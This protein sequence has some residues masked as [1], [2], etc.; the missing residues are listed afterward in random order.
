M[1]LL[2]DLE[3]STVD[4]DRGDWLDSIEKI[5]CLVILDLDTNN[6]EKYYDTT[7]L[8]ELG[9]GTLRAGI[10]KLGQATELAGHNIIQFDVPVLRRLHGFRT[11]AKI[12]DTLVISR[13]LYPDRPGGH[14]LESWGTKL[15]CP[16]LE[17]NEFEEF[18]LDMLEYCRRDVEL[19][20]RVYKAL[21][22]ESNTEAWRG[23]IDLEHEFAR[24]ITEQEQIGFY[25]DTKK[26]ERLVKEWEDAI[27]LGDSMVLDGVHSRVDAG[28]NYE[29]PFKINGDLTKR[30]VD[31][32]TAT[33]IDPSTVCGPFST[34]TYKVPELE[35]KTQQ[36]DLLLSMGWK[37]KQFTPTGAP[38]LC[39]SIKEVGS[40][41][42]ILHRRNMLSHRRSQVQGLLD[43][44][45]QF[46]R[47]HG[48]G[49][50]CG[51]N[52]GRMRHSR[53]VNIPRVTSPLGKELRSLFTVPTNKRLVGYDAAALEL[54]VLAHYIG[55]ED[56]VERV[57]TTDRARN[58][59]TLAAEAAG[60]DDY[61]TGKTINYA[62]IYGAGDSKLGSIVN[63]T[64]KDGER[65]REALYSK[66]PGFESLVT[67]AKGTARRGW[68]L[69]L[70]G[71]RL[72][73]RRRV[74]PL[75]TL[76]QGGGAIFMKTV[77]VELD[78]LAK[79]LQSFK[80]IDMHDEAQ[81]E[82]PP[83]EVATLSDYVHQAFDRATAKLNLRC[84]MEAEVKVGKT[85]MET[86]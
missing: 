43:Q 82:C 46:S 3:T 55:D 11:D 52:T 57:T 30:V 83:S 36:K 78:H 7:G 9:T 64:S 53:I 28:R 67:R 10:E 60:V 65:I 79:D 17:F 59:H 37:P 26:A 20:G 44:Q 86:H 69:G 62:L 85:W 6:I 13:T 70:D 38:K 50:P 31:V 29:R 49:N 27:A 32:C 21:E 73:L 75:N 39:D 12:T 24:I 74:S 34:F 80:V 81:W 19:N 42:E 15:G 1:R 61:D 4:F 51:T 25:F 54:R 84:P 22:A 35:S 33:G 72:Y 71:R 58:A 5:H 56:Y 2:F 40:I 66:I 68:L 77:A 45:D 63:G 47:V 23:A 14:S 48:G 41:G 18:T 8:R 16:K 76:I